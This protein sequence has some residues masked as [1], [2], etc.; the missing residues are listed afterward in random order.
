M[1]I[2]VSGTPEAELY[3]ERSSDG[4]G[5]AVCRALSGTDSGLQG[6]GGF[7]WKTKRGKR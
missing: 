2:H 3:Q 6:E 5:R 7:R 4:E 1:V